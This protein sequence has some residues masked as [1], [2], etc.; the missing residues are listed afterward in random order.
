MIVIPTRATSIRTKIVR[1]FLIELFSTWISLFMVSM[2]D[3]ASGC[4]I[5]K[6]VTR[7]QS[8]RR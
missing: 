4:Q 5:K 2:F 8:P 7:D 3:R 6:A 1:Y